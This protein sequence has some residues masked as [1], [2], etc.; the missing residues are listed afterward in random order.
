VTSAHAALRAR[1]CRFR[2]VGSVGSWRHPAEVR[3]RAW[4][5][6]CSTCVKVSNVILCQ[7]A[8]AKFAW[9]S[10][11]QSLLIAASRDQ[12]GVIQIKMEK[13]MKELLRHKYALPDTRPFVR[14]VVAPEAIGKVR[15]SG[16]ISSNRN[17]KLV[18][19]AREAG[20]HLARQFRGIGPKHLQVYLNQICYGRNRQNSSIFT[21]LLSNCAQSPTITY[22]MLTGRA[23]TNLLRRVPRHNIVSKLAV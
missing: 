13:Q 15:V 18:Q 21:L 6:T 1:A 14:R 12:C 11:E 4:R 8:N 10:Q 22:P 17:H 2:G 16:L 5:T 3:S 23:S 20:R 9:A 19:I 7:R